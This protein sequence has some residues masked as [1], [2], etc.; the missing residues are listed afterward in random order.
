MALP[1]S[2][3]AHIADQVGARALVPLGQADAL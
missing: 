3:A 2:A 1:V